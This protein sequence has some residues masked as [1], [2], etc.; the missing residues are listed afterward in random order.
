MVMTTVVHISHSNPSRQDRDWSIILQGSYIESDLI[1]KY[2]NT[3]M[4]GSARAVRQDLTEVF[5]S[6]GYVNYEGVPHTESFP[7]LDMIELKTSTLLVA[8]DELRVQHRHNFQT[9][10]AADQKKHQSLISHLENLP[11]AKN[12]HGLVH[13]DIGLA[14]SRLM[15]VSPVSSLL[16]LVKPIHWQPTST[17]PSQRELRLPSPPRVR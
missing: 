8:Q 17:D 1:K 3:M 4:R 16:L 5:N 15:D 2:R 13:R 9:A 10:W 6:R 11:Y 14:M 7:W 12:V